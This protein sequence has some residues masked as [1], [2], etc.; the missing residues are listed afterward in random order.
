MTGRVAPRQLALSLGYTESLAR[1]DFLEGPSNAAALALV[2]QWPEWPARAAFIIG[3]AGSGKSHL[4]AIWAAL[5]GARFIAARS[6][7]LASVPRALATGALVVE[8]LTPGQL[9][10]PALF[11]L[12]NLAVEQDASLLLTARTGPAGLSLGLPD[13]LSRLR[14]L[15]TAT[16]RPPDDALFRA[17]LI[18]LFA[19]RQIKVD[20]GLISY[21]TT[22][23]ERSFAA[24]RTAVDRLDRRALHLKRPLNRA[25]ASELFSS[26]D[27]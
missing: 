2:E 15:P 17:V 13:L 12:L 4:A 20:E 26:E 11:H 7:D 8:D 22:R 21:L 19:D 25:L 27:T 16:L 10:E 9:H 23:L 18:K 5:S 14:A 6:L 24:A 3:P 1:D